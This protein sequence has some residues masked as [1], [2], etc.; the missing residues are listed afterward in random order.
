MAAMQK[1]TLR[2]G[3][4][5]PVHEQNLMKSSDS[6]L[7]NYYCPKFLFPTFSPHQRRL[8][9]VAQVGESRA[10]HM[11]LT[12]STVY[13]QGRFERRIAPLANNDNQLMLQHPMPYPFFVLITYVFIVLSLARVRVFAFLLVFP[14]SSVAS[15][16]L[17]CK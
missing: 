2:P 8:K 16:C 13:V 12:K 5:Q 3:A 9:S 1:K 10:I 4:G 7:E 17:V 11:G 14:E 15:V 6:C